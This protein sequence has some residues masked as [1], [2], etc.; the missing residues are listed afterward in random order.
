MDTI[1][2][3]QPKPNNLKKILLGVIGGLFFLIV[4]LLILDALHVISLSRLFSMKNPFNGPLNARQHKAPTEVLIKVG[5]ENIYQQDLTA[6]LSYF[7]ETEN[8][9]DREK[10]LIEK[11]I[12][13]STILQAAQEE[14]LITLDSS[15]YNSA[16]KDYLK[17]IKLI[18]DVKDQL[19]KKKD[20]YKGSV[21]AVW[22]YN[23]RPGD[24]GYDRGKEIAQ[25][26]ITG[27]RN[28]VS[29]K[30]IT[31]EEAGK[32]IQ[33]DSALARVDPAYKANAYFSF[34]TELR[35][36][37]VFDKDFN[38]IIKQLQEGQVSP[39]TVVKDKEMVNGQATGKYIQAAYM[40]AQVDQ[41][42]IT[43]QN[44]GFD[45]WLARRLKKYEVIYY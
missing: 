35:E 18:A 11:L 10:L 36:D 21:V 40:F 24:V 17:R 41:R 6:E 29:G 39:V 32:D 2:P 44:P 1:Q 26:K 42:T 8:T 27:L 20:R 19:D 5:N 28:A 30:Q 38:T 16:A 25:K 37:I 12:K 31:M 22:F 15:V 33:N 34:D 14:A 7:P 13:D 3:V 45:D 9:V 23:T 4:I 43:G